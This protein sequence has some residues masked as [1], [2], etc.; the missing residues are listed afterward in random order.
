MVRY[1]LFLE[2]MLWW[3]RDW[4]GWL[5]RR[6]SEMLL[7]NCGVFCA[8]GTGFAGRMASFQQVIHNAQWACEVGLYRVVLV[9]IM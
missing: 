6:E 2:N 7:V 8:A 9:R 4:A 3:G 5:R 1:K